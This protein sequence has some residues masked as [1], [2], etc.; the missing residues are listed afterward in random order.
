MFLSLSIGPVY[1]YHSYFSIGPASPT[2]VKKTK[3][4]ENTGKRKCKADM[5]F[6]N[7]QFTNNNAWKS[8]ARLI[9]FIIF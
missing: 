6:L 9:C 4:Q 3:K 7:T 1:I 5:Y 8:A 2:V